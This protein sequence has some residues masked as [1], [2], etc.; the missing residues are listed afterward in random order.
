[1]SAETSPEDIKSDASKADAV[2]AESAALGLPESIEV[3]SQIGTGGMG[4][5]YHARNRANGMDLA[6]KVLRKQQAEDQKNVQRF[7]REAKTLTHL[8]N[9]HIVRV[10]DFGTTSDGIPYILMDYA[11]GMPLDECIISGGPVSPEEAIELAMQ[12]AEALG[13]AHDNGIVHRDLKPSNIMVNMDEQGTISV[14]L[15]DFGISKFFDAEKADLR[16][17]DTGQVMGTPLYMSPEQV[18]GKDIDGR[19]DIYALGCVIYE[20]LTANPPFLATDAYIVLAQHVQEVPEDIATFRSDVPDGFK[21]VVARMME[22]QPEDR[23]QTMHELMKDLDALREKREVHT[24]LTGA[25]KRYIKMAIEA[26][27]IAAICFGVG[28]LI[29]H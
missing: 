1:M 17:T 26:L 15:L 24:G 7:M 9:P 6:A 27:S 25:Q 21:R 14:K 2:A 20:V 8:S 3:L 12:C 19:A 11:A 18:L 4:I 28:Y 23:Y 29:M 22:K 16:L 13:H 5:V 10:Y